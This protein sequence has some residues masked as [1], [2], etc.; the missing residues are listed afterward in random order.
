M[1]NI[2]IVCNNEFLNLLYVMNLE[3]YLGASTTLV[4]GVAGAIESLSSKKKFDLILTVSMANKDNTAK[5]IEAYLKSYGKKIPM[6]IVG[7]TKDEVINEYIIAINAKF[8]IQIILRHCAK[9]LA[10]T[11]KQMAELDVGSYYPIS[12]STLL[13]FT[14]A[15]CQLFS[16]VGEVY[17]SLAK[18]GDLIENLLIELNNKVVRKLHVKSSDRLIIVNI[19]SLTIV[20]KIKKSLEDLE[21]SSVEKKINVLSS[22]FEFAS[23]NI[24]SSDEIKKE[25]QEIA[26]SASLVMVAVAK[27]N[28]SLKSLMAILMENKDG[29]IFTHSMIASYV[30]YHMIKNVA[31]GGE[32]QA[33]KINFVLFF[34]DIFLAPI[35][36]KHPELR[37]ESTLL[38]NIKLDEK[39]NDIVLNHAR[40]AAELVVTYKRCPIGADVLIKQHHGMKKGKGFVR[41]Y[42]EDLSPISKV[43]LVAEMYVEE[44]LKANEEKKE[45]NPKTLIPKLVTLFKSP[46]YTKLVQSLIHVPL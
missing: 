45:F 40:L 28:A 42:V 27:E 25:M 39:E 41:A 9:L 4:L 1:R 35:Y 2:L 31:W 36:L 33:E 30:A 44:F 14:K 37:G 10:I 6:I 38:N 21:G 43:I 13:G 15:P 23:A 29:Y 32:T 8:Q 22:G 19:I 3:V 26:S 16:K 18:E 7:H 5:E 24:F 20:E 46:S 17:Q 12:L 34:H 11:A